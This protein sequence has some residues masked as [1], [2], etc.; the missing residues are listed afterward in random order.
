M[1]SAIAVLLFLFISMNGFSQVGIGTT[2]PD[3]SAILDLQS[4]SQGFLLPRMNTYQQSTIEDPVTGLIIFNI[5]SADIYF[6]NDS[7]WLSLRDISD[8]IHPWSCGDSFIDERDGQEYTTVQ[9]GTQCWMAENINVGSRIN[10]SLDMQNNN[11]IEKYCYNNLE[12]NCDIYGGLYQWNEMMMYT[13]TVGTQGICPIGW[14]ISTDAE[15]TV[16]ED[17]LGG[18]GIAGGKLKSIGTIEEG[19]GIWRYPNAG[20][21]NESG[22]SSIPGGRRRETGTYHLLNYTAYFW[23]SNENGSLYG[24]YRA[25][26]YNYGS[27]GRQYFP[28]AYGFSV[29]CIKD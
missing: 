4:T 11:I 17:Y 23:S 19:T 12:S 14:H 26:D 9:I 6:F 8:T 5:D 20:A 18:G 21:T 28:R 15:W 13:T 10:G 16:I 3:P 22:F 24:W 7:I 27:V 29:R 1:K 25:L 2:T